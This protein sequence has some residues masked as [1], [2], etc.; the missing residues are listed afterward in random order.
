ENPHL[1]DSLES[2]S[3][4]RGKILQETFIDG[5]DPSV[6]RRVTYL[7]YEIKW[8]NSTKIWRN[9]CRNTSTQHAE[10]NFLENAFRER[11]FNPLT[12]CS[13]TWFLSWSPCWKCSQSVVE[14]LKTYPKV[15]LE[16]YVA[17]LF[18]H[19]D[20]SNRLGLRDLVMNGVTIRVMDLSGNHS[21]GFKEGRRINR[22]GGL[23]YGAFHFYLILQ[24]QPNDFKVNYIPGICPR[25]TYLLYEIRWG[26]ST[27]FWRHWCRNTPTQHAEI[28]CL[29]H[30]FKKLK[31]RPSV[32]CS[33]TWFLSWSPCGKCCRCIVEFVRAHPSVTLKIKAAWL[34]KHMDERNRQGLRNLMENGVALYIMNL[35][36]I[37]TTLW[38]VREWHMQPLTYRAPF[39]IQFQAR[40]AGWVEGVGE[41]NMEPL[42][43]SAAVRVLFL[44]C[45]DQKFRSARSQSE[46]FYERS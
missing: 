42:I 2:L 37:L 33:I 44:G 46:Q 10:I 18:W 45:S 4:F 15:N 7:L 14:F 1:N 16:M 12:H 32:R 5:Y 41:W 27:K 21:F 25:V 35:P 17:R 13:I 28:A 29:E 22:F 26:R 38:S 31:F 9:W 39:P 40:E 24:I 8:G 34:F 36:G 11:S 30:D 20:R 6:L 43:Y 3:C 23:G 19:E